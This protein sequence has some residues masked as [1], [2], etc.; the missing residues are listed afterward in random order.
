VSP[1]QPQS[2]F[3]AKVPTGSVSPAHLLVRELPVIAVD[4]GGQLDICANDCGGG[5]CKHIALPID[6]PTN[7][8]DHDSIRWYLMHEDI[9]VYKYESEWFLTVHRRCRHLRPDNICGNYDRRPQTCRDYD[10]SE[11][12]QVGEVDYEF[13]FRDDDEY[14]AWIAVASKRRSTAARKG[15]AKRKTDG[16]VAG[17]RRSRVNTRRP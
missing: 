12:E 10:A 3:V 6:T 4:P 9:D 11:C 15:W 14:D 7:K 2:S 13:Y 1:Q 8:E 17:A 16:S 5:C